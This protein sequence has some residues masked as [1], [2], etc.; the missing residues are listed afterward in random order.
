MF[1]NGSLRIS[2]GR[3]LIRKDYRHDAA[4]TVVLGKREDTVVQHPTVKVHIEI[5]TVR[6]ISGADVVVGDASL[7]LCCNLKSASF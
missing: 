5:G 4:A 2:S 3:K 1:F 7:L 6:F